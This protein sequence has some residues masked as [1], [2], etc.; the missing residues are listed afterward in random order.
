MR[1]LDSI[2]LTRPADGYPVGTPGTIVGIERDVYCVEI[3]EDSM[4]PGD[5]LALVSVP[6]GAIRLTA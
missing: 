2:E 5:E 3:A 6:A 4:R 1:E